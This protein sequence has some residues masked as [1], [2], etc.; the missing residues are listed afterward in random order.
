MIAVA[1]HRG[2]SLE[3]CGCLDIPWGGKA[4]KG[5]PGGRACQGKDIP[6]S[7]KN[8]KRSA[9]LGSMPGKRHTLRLE[10]REKVCPTGKLARE[11]TY[12]EA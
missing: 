9:Q 6:W 2:Y 4:R 5:L 1:G 8:M 10:K 7:W 11:K 3:L 12:P